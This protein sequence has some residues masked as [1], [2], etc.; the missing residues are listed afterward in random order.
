MLQQSYS[1]NFYGSAE[2]GK[3]PLRKPSFRWLR[4]TYLMCAKCAFDQ[5][6]V[7]QGAHFKCK[8]SYNPQSTW[9][10]GNSYYYR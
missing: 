9:N 6:R 3:S 1:K 10:A 2:L 4:N 8:R 5:S 7:R